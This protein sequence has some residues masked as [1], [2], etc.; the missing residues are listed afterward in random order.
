MT[1]PE[2]R[3]LAEVRTAILDGAALAP[4]GLPYLE[5]V[6]LIARAVVT[7]AKMLPAEISRER[8]AE[9]QLFASVALMDILAIARAH[10]QAMGLATLTGGPAHPLA[11]VRVA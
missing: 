4:Q 3:F 2:I 7:A 8:Q 6:A 9:L 1:P 11:N 5:V 10:Q